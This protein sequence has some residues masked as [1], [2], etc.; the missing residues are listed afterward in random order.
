[1]DIKKTQVRHLEQL[2]DRNQ[3][4]RSKMT[5]AKMPKTDHG[6]GGENE[7]RGWPQHL[8]SCP[9][10]ETIQ[11]LPAEHPLESSIAAGKG[12]SSAS[13]SSAWKSKDAGIV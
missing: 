7:P 2:S 1:M 5:F 4:T 3:S 13:A 12:P 8:A 9:K 11:G 10:K 6:K